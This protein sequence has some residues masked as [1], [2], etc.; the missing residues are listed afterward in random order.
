MRLSTLLAS[1]AALPDLEA[2]TTESAIREMI[3]GL[4]ARDALAAPLQDDVLVAL[5]KRESTSTTGLG[6]GVALPHA[7]LRAI[8]DFVC[9]VGVSRRGIDFRASD[10][11][12]VLAVFLLLSP[13][14]DPYGHLE[15]MGVIGGLVRQ[16]GFVTHLARCRTADSLVE[17]IEQAER[18][19]F[20]DG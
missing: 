1:G 13:L 2:S 6:A 19:L 17:T 18:K 16:D 10:R 3:D 15:L 20:P 11:K 7:K 12:P 4:V 14:D 8:P 5:L 9:A